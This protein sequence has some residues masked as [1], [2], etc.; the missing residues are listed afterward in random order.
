[1]SGT[2]WGFSVRKA[3]LIFIISLFLTGI[4]VQGVCAFTDGS[5]CTAFDRCSF[6]S[7]SGTYAERQVKEMD[8]LLSPNGDP[9]A[10]MFAGPAA[11]LNGSQSPASTKDMMF[12]ASLVDYGDIQYFIEE[13]SD[14]NSLYSYTVD[15]EAICDRSLPEIEKEGLMYPKGPVISF[16]YDL[17][18]RVFAGIDYRYKESGSGED[19]G[20][21]RVYEIINENAGELDP[22]YE[23]PP[24][25]F[26]RAHMPYLD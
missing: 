20:I 6:N 12:H 23:F 26:S 1:M 18:M 4:P 2:V 22:L 9:A 3:G 11:D 8:F 15:A 7:V 25:I 19:M 16:G 13:H 14:K 5:D 17:K 21:L 24:V 10:I